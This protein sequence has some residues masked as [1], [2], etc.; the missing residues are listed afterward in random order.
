MFA[1]RT[2]WTLTTNEVTRT[3]R[4][5]KAAGREVI[6]LTVSNPTRCGLAYPP[7]LCAAF[8]DP[9]NLDYDPQ[10]FGLL[11]ARQAVAAYYQRRG[12][13]VDPRRVVLT[14]S[15]SEGY[16]MLFR[17]LTDPGDRVLFPHP[18]YPLFQYLA[19]INDVEPLGYALVH[20]GRGGWVPDPDGWPALLSEDPRAIIV[21]NPNNP[22][23]S[24]WTTGMTEDLVSAGA[25]EELAF[26]VD[27]VFWDYPLGA[28]GFL[29]LAG[30]KERLTFVLGGLSKS[31]G[32][33]QMKLS[34]M[35]VSGPPALA[36]AALQRLEVIADTSLSVA[37]PV[38]HALPRWLA[39][40]DQWQDQL[41]QRLRR[42][43]AAVDQVLAGSRLTA[44][45]AQGGW[46]RVARLPDN[47]EEEAFMLKALTENG[48]FVHPGYFFDFAPDTGYIVISLLVQEP[49][50]REGLRR[51]VM[52]ADRAASLR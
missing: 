7:E 5:M 25:S 37:A 43:T 34:W 11:P 3:L 6:D 36:D 14:A 17:L 52:T 30:R 24:F 12:I 19:E 46:Y 29:S 2:G 41:R 1:R 39:G 32:L 44:L 35:I 45:P 49:E 40:A 38:Q 15:T 10:S 42:N 27:E 28:A 31:L 21:V 33:P 9:A 48:V 23:G 47:I 13:D 16:T 18:S 51:V 22:T 8:D 50:L 4:D 26:I 20:D